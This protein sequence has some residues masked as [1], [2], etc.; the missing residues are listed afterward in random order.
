MFNSSKAWSSISSNMNDFEK[1]CIRLKIQ[2][3]L[4]RNLRILENDYLNVFPVPIA[5]ILECFF[6][7]CEIWRENLRNFQINDIMKNAKM[8]GEMQL[9]F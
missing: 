7:I 1:H 5:G 3:F 4:L 2:T 9:Q 8:F 6:V